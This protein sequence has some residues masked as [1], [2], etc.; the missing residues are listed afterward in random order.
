M[1]LRPA[2]A[3]HLVISKSAVKPHTG[4]GGYFTP[5]HRLC[6]SSQTCRQDRAENFEETVTDTLKFKKPLSSCEY[7]F[8]FYQDM[9]GSED[10]K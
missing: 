3:V 4:D 5:Q 10:E 7:I 1:D 2:D 8:P 6:Y 9:T